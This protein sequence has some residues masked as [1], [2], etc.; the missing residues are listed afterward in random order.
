MKTLIL[1]SPAKINLYLK[2]E[3]KRSDG[4]HDISTLFERIS[5]YDYITFKTTTSDKIKVYCDNPLVP[6][7]AA[8]FAFIAAK[9]LREDFASACGVEINIKKNIPV[10]AGLGGGSSNAAYVL[11][12]LN[13]LWGLKLTKKVIIE[14]AKKIGADVSFFVNNK[15]FAI[16]TERG[17]NI[18]PLNIKKVLWHVLVVPDLAV[19]TRGTYQEYKEDLRLTKPVFNTTIITRILSKGKLLDIEPF[20]YNDLERVTIKRYRRIRKIINTLRDLGSISGMSG[21]GPTV[22]GITSTRAKAEKIK[23]S[24]D[25]IK[26]VRVIVVRTF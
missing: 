18:R 23:G 22:F 16:G 11:L 3:G 9:L 21:S 14:Y 7:G 8:N 19:S 12:G 20:I 25:K 10:A 1:K 5:I 6:N 24:V 13:R 17:D 26:G 4:Y 15:S 2:I